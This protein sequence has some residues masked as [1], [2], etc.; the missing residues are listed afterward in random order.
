[1]AASDQALARLN[2]LILSDPALQAALDE[3]ENLEAFAVRAAEAARAGGL[4]LDAAAI[5][6]VLHAPPRPPLIGDL[7]PMPGWRP[8][9]ATRTD[10][11]L[12]LDW[13][14]FGR[15]LTGPFYGD[16]VARARRRPLNR[17][18]AFRTPLAGLESWA[19]ASPPRAPDGLIFHMSRC[20]STLAARMLAAS[21]AHVVVSEAAPLD[22]V[23]RLASLDEAARVDALRAMVAVLGQAHAGERR[24]FLKLDSWHV[25]DLP[26]FRRAFPDAP[27]VFLY[28]DPVEVMVSHLRLRGMQMVPDLVPPATFGL[29]LGDEPPDEDYCAQVLAAVCEA[30]VRGHGRGGGLLVDH[31]QLPDALFTA[32][33]PHFGVAVSPAEAQVMR[34]AATRDAKA[35]NQAF[36]P[37]AADKQRAATAAVRA[38]C[39]RR[40]DGVYARL[41]ALRTGRA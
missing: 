3:I 15:R 31:G 19:T 13:V 40:L 12:V 20:G 29:D 11:E 27:W 34:E 9:E 26:L 10:G 18:A 35:P 39:E 5:G 8:A 21:P 30:A 22:A 24:L 38:I 23:V 36:R 32:I 16:D 41:E 17:L 6:D 28:R 37:D 33:L 25:L 1:M 7:A 4:A 2:A 14:R